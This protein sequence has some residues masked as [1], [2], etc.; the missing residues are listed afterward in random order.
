MPMAISSPR[1]TFRKSWRKQP[2]GLLLHVDLA[3]KVHAVAHLHELVGVARV[4]VFAG[5]FAS[6]I[7]IDR[8]G[9]RHARAEVQRFS[10]DRAGSV[11]YSI[12]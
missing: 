9:K 10:S 11:K 8:P 3:L 1:F 6:A 4:A 7:G 5:E 12:R 2:G